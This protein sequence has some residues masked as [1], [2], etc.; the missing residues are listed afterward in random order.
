MGSGL[1]TLFKLG[2]KRIEAE[3]RAA[4]LLLKTNILEQDVAVGLSTDIDQLKYNDVFISYRGVSFDRHTVIESAIKKGIAGVV[5][6]DPAYSSGLDTIFFLVK[7]CRKAWAVLCAAGY[8]HPEQKLDILGVTGTNGK[9]STVWILHYLL[10]LSGLRGV[11]IG[12]LG[13]MFPDEVG[14]ATHTTPDPPQLFKILAKAVDDNCQ[15]VAMEVSSIAI[16]QGKLDFLKF[17]CGGFTS[18]SQDHLD[19]HGTMANY[20]ADKLRFFGDLV[21]GKRFAWGGLREV[22]GVWAQLPKD[23]LTYGDTEQDNYRYGCQLSSGGMTPM[24]I[25]KAGDKTYSGEIKF[26]SGYGA[27]NFCLAM[28][29]AENYLGS[30]IGVDTWREVPSVPGRMEVVDSAGWVIVDYAHTPDALEN[31]L[32]ECKSFANKVCVVF[33]CGGDRDKSKRRLMGAIACRLATR[34]V[35]TSDNPRSENPQKIINDI[36]AGVSGAC[37]LSS[38][39]DRRNAIKFA[40]ESRED[41]EVVLIAGKGHETYQEVTG[42]RYDFDDRE[43]ARTILKSIGE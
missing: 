42:V 10:Q 28:M 14:D 19:Y 37:D 3:L 34:L 30:A 12:T 38:D 25:S 31:A 39:L 11:T 43:V 17:L 2:L 20:L 23:T 18:F 8:N 35:I 21:V 7:D 1:S 36:L 6:D 27:Q 9:T 15:Y 4:N 33:G 13:V 5:L 32:L 16:N 26:G 24:S 29:M 22:D 40:L 41:Q